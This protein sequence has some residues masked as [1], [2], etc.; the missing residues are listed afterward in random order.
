[1]REAAW[2][3]WSFQKEVTR[4]TQSRWIELKITNE[5]KKEQDMNMSYITIIFFGI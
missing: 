5:K 2:V 1:M 3:L 4:D